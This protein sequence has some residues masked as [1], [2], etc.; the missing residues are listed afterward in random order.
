MVGALPLAYVGLAFGA[1]CPVRWEARR[2]LSYG[3]S[4]YAWPIQQ[5]LV[6][7]GVQRFSTIVFIAA[8]FGLVQPLA[9][10]SWTFR[11]RSSS[12][13]CAPRQ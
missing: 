3:L 13:T 8:A 10:L 4:L 7:M 9:W 2:D 11:A 12:G 6:L 1:W 5:V